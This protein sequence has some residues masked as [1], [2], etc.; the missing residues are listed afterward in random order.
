[1]E[2][3]TVKKRDNIVCWKVDAEGACP[4]TLID[5]D[6]GITLLIK[7][8]GKS[9]VCAKSGITLHSLFNPG[10]TSKLFGGKK[11]YGSCDI[12]AVNTTSDFK[13]EWALA[14]GKAM[15]CKDPEFDCEAKAIAR[16]TYMHRIKD[17]FRFV[18]NFSFEARVDITRENAREYFRTEAEN[19]ISPYLAPKVMAN[20]VEGV[21]SH[22]GE[23]TEDIKYHLNRHLAERGVEVIS[24]AV[25]AIDYEPAHKI[26][27]E[28]LKKAK[29]GVTIKGVVND[30]RRDD[31]S[32][33]KEASEIEIGLIKAM[34]G[35]GN[36]K[37]SEGDA[38]P[39]I[40]CPRCGE[41]NNAGVNYCSRCGEKLGK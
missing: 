13:C 38:K 11:A 24:F 27:R 34:N 14:A 33:D 22:I 21:Q 5:I 8:D 6:A 12:Y 19:V 25:D 31:I 40:I 41:L 32:V 2:K 20:G 16:G 30:G 29:I 7:A 1:M 4:N 17:Y 23:Y 37:K 35:G 36:A 15:N 3:L 39:Q 9:N 26:H 28:E 10:K 18:S